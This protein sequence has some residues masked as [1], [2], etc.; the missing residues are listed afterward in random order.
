MTGILLEHDG[1]VAFSQGYLNTLTFEYGFGTRYGFL[2]AADL[3]GCVVNLG[4]KGGVVYEAVTVT[5]AEDGALVLEGG[6]M[7]W[8]YQDR[9]P[10]PVAHETLPFTEVARGFT[11][12]VVNTGRIRKLL[13][14][15]VERHYRFSGAQHH[16]AGYGEEYGN[17][18][19]LSNSLRNH[20]GDAVETAG[21]WARDALENGSTA[22][23][24]QR[25]DLIEAIVEVLDG[26]DH[27]GPAYVVD[28]FRAYTRVLRGDAAEPPP[29]GSPPG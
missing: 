18:V 10:E 25:A 7:G 13:T 5:A 14:A 26:V 29:P 6:R 15:T 24:T 21:R 11:R 19:A 20:P 1:L 23:C 27:D 2:P 4:D 16:V 17:I 12:P 9:P 22:G 28:A 8:L 3:V